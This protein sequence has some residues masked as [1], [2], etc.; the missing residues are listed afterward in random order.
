MHHVNN[1]TAKYDTIYEKYFLNSANINVLLKPEPT[2]LR[3]ISSQN[4][5]ASL[6]PWG[7]RILNNT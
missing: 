5:H 3:L 7:C 1:I 4:P 2:V 6:H